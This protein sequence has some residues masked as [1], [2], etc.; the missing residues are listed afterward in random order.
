MTFQRNAKFKFLCD[1]CAHCPVCGYMLEAAD[2]I[3]L[4]EKPSKQLERIFDPSPVRFILEGMRC[5]H[6]SLAPEMHDVSE[7]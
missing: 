3:G 7:L 4:S 6:F 2:V 1:Q 5:E